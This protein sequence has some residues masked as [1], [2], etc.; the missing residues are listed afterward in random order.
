[1]GSGQDPLETVRRLKATP[2]RIGCLGCTFTGP[3]GIAAGLLLLIVVIYLVRH[4]L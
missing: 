1:M 3:A 4:F 2:A